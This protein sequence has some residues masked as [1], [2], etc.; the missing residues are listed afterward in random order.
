MQ[1]K[2][3]FRRDFYTRGIYQYSLNVAADIKLFSN[4]CDI[5]IIYYFYKIR[6]TTFDWFS[7]FKIQ[8]FLLEEVIKITLSTK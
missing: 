5:N 2:L 6:K 7:S 3:H 4:G 8:R 1:E